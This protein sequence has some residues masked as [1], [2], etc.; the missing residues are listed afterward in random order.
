LGA[1]TLPYRAYP[2]ERAL[3]GIAR[4]GFRYVGVWNEHSGAQL[5]PPDAGAPAIQ[6]VRRQ[7]EASG[8]A[9]RMAFRFPAA[10]SDPAAALRRT[11]E[12][13]AELGV[14]YVLSSGPS[15][16][17]KAF[18]ER[19]RDMLFL[20]EAQGYFA[21]LREVAPLAERAGVTIVMK[22][23]MGVT[24]TGE[25]LADIVELI[26]HPHVRICYDA[27]NVA[28]Y[29]GLKPEDDVATCAEYVRAVCVKDHRG[30]RFHPDFPVPGDGEVDHAQIFGTLLGAGFS[31]PA[32][33]ERVDG[34]QR[35]TDMPAEMIDA[36]LER[37][38]RAL[39]TAAAMAE[40]AAA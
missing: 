7:I 18:A 23:H 25:D 9:P 33:V 28:F 24:G 4:A 5:V 38:R 32:L 17:R 8:L 2:F 14:P 6:A 27:G 26:D 30:P 35:A 1:H 31:G 3:E 10:G 21:A 11:I 13:G 37:A 34:Q 15:P 19:K 12:V 36:A 16:Y 29:E 40:G 20:R 39:A 22:P